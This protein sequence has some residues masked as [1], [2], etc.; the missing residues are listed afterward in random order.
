MSRSLRTL[1]M[2]AVCCLPSLLM[3]AEPILLGLNYP[4]TGRLKEDGISEAMGA[5]LAV[6]EINAAGGVLGRPLQLLMANTASKPEKSVENVRQMA[7]QGAVMVFGGATSPVAIAGGQEAARHR[8][9]YF[10]T[11]TYANETTGIEGQR[12]MFRECHNAWMIGKALS[13]YIRRQLPDERFFFVTADY[14]WGT[15]TEQ[16]LREQANLQDVEKHP[17]ARVSFPKP[18]QQEIESAIQT[19]AA[20]DAGVL[21]LVLNGEDLITGLRLLHDLKLDER[22]KV[23]APSVTLGIARAAGASL[24]EGVV[25]TSP[26]E[27]NIP[28]QLN[29]P[30]GQAFVEAFVKRFNQYP[31][32][33]AAS[34]Y[35]IVYQFKDAAERAGSVNGDK[36]VTA[37]E[38]Y[39]YTG[40]KDEQ[41]WRAFD[42]QNL[43]TLYVIQGKPRNEILK[44]KF[45]SDF[46]EVVDQLS[47]KDGAMPQ[48]QWLAERQKAGKPAQLQ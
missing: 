41:Q 32:S 5:E 8:I 18:R 10:G 33:P 17:S 1:A 23:I 44:D 20:S 37:L 45:R 26:W 31:A 14:I 27:W 42:H 35:S 38:G 15:S 7:E 16:S 24:M 12:F 29:Y 40:L 25:T 48:E 28:Y 3:A 13:N 2:L 47:A 19:A 4:A 34:A 21:V 30:R 39:R 22:F 46:F 6:A 36:L 11:L 43:Q 9:P